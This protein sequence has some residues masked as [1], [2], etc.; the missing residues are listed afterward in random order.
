MVS[1]IWLCFL[2]YLQTQFIRCLKG[3]LH[4]LRRGSQQAEGWHHPLWWTYLWQNRSSGEKKRK[5]RGGW[6]RRDET[7]SRCWWRAL[8][9][10]CGCSLDLIAKSSYLSVNHSRQLFKHWSHTCGM[11]CREFDG[12]LR[13]NAD[14]LREQTC[15]M[16][17][18]D[19]I[20]I[21]DTQRETQS[22]MKWRPIFLL[23]AFKHWLKAPR[24]HKTHP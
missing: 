1:P 2:V 5:R 6:G 9:L 14:E 22:A 4:S 20:R 21:P 8:A 15:K 19:A 24:V 23:A 17:F 11:T 12:F 10:T 18:I 3:R 13:G 16:L 7:Q